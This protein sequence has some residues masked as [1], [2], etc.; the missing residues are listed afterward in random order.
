[1]KLKTEGDETMTIGCIV[2]DR[3]EISRYAKLYLKEALKDEIMSSLF[4]N[5]TLSFCKFFMFVFFT[6]NCFFVWC[7]ILCLCIFKEIFV[8]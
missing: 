7:S 3:T 4:E 6:L 8:D 2:N 1:M 5:I